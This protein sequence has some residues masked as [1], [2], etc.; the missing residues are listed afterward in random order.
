[1][2]TYADD[3]RQAAALPLPWE[4]LDGCNLLVTGA[5]GLIG[6]CLVEVLMSRP[7]KKY[8][9]YAAGRD[10]SR[11]QALFAAFADDPS[12]HFLP[13]DVT[14]PLPSSVGFDYIVHAASPAS[15][16]FFAQHPV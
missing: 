16:R 5:T 2:T 12:F 8:R 1:M 9:V 7:D 14:R 13:C 10:E 15:P 3:I 6:S 11:A 4:Q